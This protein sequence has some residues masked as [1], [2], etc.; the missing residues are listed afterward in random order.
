MLGDAC[1]Y[2][3]NS[4][5]PVAVITNLKGEI[6]LS[7]YLEPNKVEHQGYWV[8]SG[9]RAMITRFW[10][11]STCSVNL[12][13][14]LPTMGLIPKV[15]PIQINIE[16]EFCLWL[17]YIEQVRPVIQEDLA[18]GRLL[19]VFIGII[20]NIKSTASATGGYTIQLQARDRMKWFMDSSVYFNA[21][22]LTKVNNPEVEGGKSSTAV[23]RSDIIHS[24]ARKSVGVGEGDACQGCGKDIMLNPDWVVDVATGDSVLQANAWYGDANQPLVGRTRI[25]ESELIV[26][27]NP[28][29]RIYTT[30]VGIETSAAG[31]NFLLNGQTPV[32]VIKTL[33][34]QEV[35]PTE[36]FQNHRDGNFY[37]YPRANDSTSLTDPKRFFRTYYFMMGGDSTN[38]NQRLLALR[39][40]KSSIGLKTNFIVAKNSPESNE[41][42]AF[43]DMML[44]LRTRPYELIGVPIACK[45]HRVH[46]PTITKYAEAAV[47][48]TSMARIW[49]RETKV[50]MAILLGDPSLVPGE[51][52]QV[53]GSPLVDYGGLDPD[54][55]VTRA[56]GDRQKFYEY[57]NNWNNL[58]G[59][60]K[61]S[62]AT[63]TTSLNEQ[64][65]GV[66]V[67]ESASKIQIDMFDKSVAH[68]NSPVENTDYNELICNMSSYLLNS[69]SNIGFNRPPETI[70]RADAVMHKFNS[71]SKG[72]STEVVLVTPF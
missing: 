67:N 55:G 3:F 6:I 43:G 25:L 5:V 22:Q 37:Y 4:T 39:E 69:Q 40:E 1:H 60:Y 23:T 21:Q 27:E 51:I 24:I 46:D 65:A 18:E 33:A 30:R 56:A 26:P 49:A 48:A 62:S 38:I 54:G 71:G 63:N 57:D 13:P 59:Q 2:S 28:E 50:G 10:A 17:G 9:A 19:R 52:L 47:I 36:F 34:F 16:R 12:V 7:S 66:T 68:Y 11:S 53:M 41:S 72:Y 14:N 58:I 15:L 20:E 45:F 8:I 64:G 29:I 70:W 44:H 32:E 31:P 42:S 61:Q 35:Y